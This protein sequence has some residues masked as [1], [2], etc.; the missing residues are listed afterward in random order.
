L[1]RPVTWSVALDFYKGRIE[2]D[3]FESVR[4]PDRGKRVEWSLAKGRPISGVLDTAVSWTIMGP[5]TKALCPAV[6]ALAKAPAIRTGSSARETAVFK[7]TP[8]N[9]HSITWHA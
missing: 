5:A 9:P 4:I 3:G 1:S 2:D 6:I 7:S 8:S